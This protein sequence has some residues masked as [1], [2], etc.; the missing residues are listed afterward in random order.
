[1]SNASSSSDSPSCT[2]PDG[3]SCW[4]C[5]EEGP[6]DSGAPLVR[7]CSCRGHSGFAHLPCIVQYAESK[8]RDFAERVVR[9]G[10]DEPLIQ[11]KFFSQCPNCKQEFQGD[12]YKDLTKA[13]LSFIEREF[14]DVECWNLE[15]MVMRIAAL[16]AKNEA[17]RIEGEEICD[18]VLS[19][20][21]DDMGS[22]KPSMEFMSLAVAYRMHIGMFYSKVGD[23][24]FLEKAKN[25]YEKARDVCN[26]FSETETFIIMAKSIK[27]DLAKIE[28]RL[29]GDCLPENAAYELS[30]L[31]D[32]YM[33]MSQNDGE[34]DIMT[35]GCGLKLAFELFRTYQTIEALRLL[36]KLLVTSRR[37]HGASHSHTKSAEHLWQRLKIRY[38]FLGEQLYQA[39]R[40]END[41]DS[42]V[43]N[44]PVDTSNLGGFLESVEDE[45]TFAVPSGDVSFTVGSPVMLHGLKKAAHLNDEIG[46][47][48]DLCQLSDRW[49]V[50]LEGN[51]SKPVKVKQENLRILFELPHPKKESP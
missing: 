7:D 2:T 45:K 26:T 49:V 39:L 43:V 33:H 21:E 1:M 18:K 40:Y 12:I 24:Q 10:H 34:N 3:E 5:L 11:E 19:M 48:R 28:A 41:G 25:C 42:C 22:S 32:A 15:A 38:V 36:D 20:I 44:G 9:S 46:D 30:G 23:D 6:D 37:V 13:Q 29:N 50:H 35:I 16:N 14:K 51:A 4:I 17:D 47:I 31:R 8:S 27:E